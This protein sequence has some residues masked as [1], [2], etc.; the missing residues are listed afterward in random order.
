M[1]TTN[2][3]NNTLE[4]YKDGMCIINQPFKPTSTGEQPNWASEAE[5]LEWWNSIKE[6]Y[7]QEPQVVTPPPLE[8]PTE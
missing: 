7:E 8:P 6:P 5:A 4:V 2:F 1:I 3:I